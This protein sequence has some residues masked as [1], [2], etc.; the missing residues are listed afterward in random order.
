MLHRIIARSALC[1]ALSLVPALRAQDTT[2]AGWTFSQFLGEGAPAI[3]AETGIDTNFITATYRGLNEPD[4]N[5]VDGSIVGQSSGAG[6]SNT[7]IGNWSFANFNATNAFDVR[8]DTNEGPQRENST[9]RDG[10]DMALTDNAGMGLTFNLGNT[11]WSISVTDTRGYANASGSDFTYAARGNGGTA[12]VEWLFNG[13][14]FSTQTIPAGSFSIYADELN[15]DFY[16]SGVIQGRVVSGSVTFDNVQFNGQLGTPPV[17]T[18]QPSSLVRLVGESATFS[19][20]A[21]GAI[22]PTYQWKKDGVPLAL[23]TSATLTLDPLTLADA[24]DYSVTVRSSNGIEAGSAAATLQVRQ[25]LQITQQPAPNSAKPGQTIS[26][27]V[28]ATGSPAASYVWQRNDVVLTDGGIISGSRTATLT[29]TG[30]AL[31]DEGNYRVKVENVVSSLFSNA[32]SLTVTALDVAPTISTPPADEVAIVGEEVELTVVASGA[33]A[34][35]YVW[36]FKGEVLANGVGVAGATSNR[37]VLSNVTAAQA[38]DYTVVVTNI[39]GLVEAKAK[40]TIPV[41]PQVVSGPGPVQQAVIAGSTVTYQVVATG[42]P[43]PAYQWLRNAL[44]IDGQT[45]DT[46]T[47]NAVTAANDGSYSVR[48][49]NAAGNVVSPVSGLSVGSAAKIV[50]GPQSALVATQASVTLSVSVTGTPAP[51]YQWLRDGKDI[52]DATAATLTLSNVSAADAGSYTV[53]VDNVFATVVSDPAV[54]RVAQAV[55]GTT[56]KAPQVFLPGSTLSLGGSAAYTGPL[57]YVW[58]RD[59]KQIAGNTGPSLFIESAAFSNSGVYSVKVYGAKNVLLSTKVVATVKISVASAYDALLRTT[60]PESPAGIISLEVADNGSFTGLLG[61]SDGKSYKFGGKF[62]FPATPLAGQA[63]V[64]IARRGQ[65]TLLLDL[66]LDAKKS[67]LD[68]GLVESGSL[69]PTRFGLGEKRRGTPSPW[70]GV[71]SLVLTPQG[72]FDPGEPTSSIMLTARITKNGS[73]ALTGTLTDGTKINTTVAGSI[74]GRYAF[75]LRPY[76]KGS[77][78]LAG[79]LVLENSPAG[80]FAD[81]S[82]GL[83]IWTREATKGITPINL[84]LAPALAP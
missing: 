42:D 46:L 9:T 61:Y 1:L 37:L 50:S 48:V 49:T 19:F 21:T 65:A 80:Y 36:K 27:Y 11:L 8:A 22:S 54:V 33:P 67:E 58:F 14:V 57:R 25:A 75:Y 59:G 34:P 4:R 5:Q 55:S 60:G 77:G 84:E 82:S 73:L 20:V 24:G 69:A 68:I 63:S 44:T 78:L 10:L 26:F 13:S 72:P 7:A 47:L 70:N 66:Q 28:I 62:S 45:T 51:T 53:R 40:L 35:S 76:R 3:N 41:P 31:A 52:Q 71:Y 2:L 30:V 38:G 56:P 83:W 12:T 23:K 15:P 79:E 39:A 29:L 43:A 81:L 64:A 17:F 74:D 16:G 6:Y 32:A 18:T